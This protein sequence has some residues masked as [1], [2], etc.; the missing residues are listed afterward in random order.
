MEPPRQGKNEER[1]NKKNKKKMKTVG[2]GN[3]RK[4]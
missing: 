2:D 1:K 4:P 3:W